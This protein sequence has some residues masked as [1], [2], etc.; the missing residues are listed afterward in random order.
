MC[1]CV[2]AVPAVK[3]VTVYYITYIKENCTV[4]Y[5]KKSIYT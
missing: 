3:T 1:V 2:C 5:A 4:I